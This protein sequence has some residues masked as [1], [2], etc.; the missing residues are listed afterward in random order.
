MM[1]QL[2]PI[3]HIK[4]RSK[5]YNQV[6]QFFS[7]KLILEVETPLLKQ[8]TVTDPY[9]ESLSVKLH[10][11][12][13]Y[14]Q[15]SP[16]FS[17]KSMIAAG[18]GDVFQICKA[19][20]YDEFSTHHQPEFSMLEWYRCEMN[21]HDLMAEAVSLLKL[22]FG[23]LSVQYASYESIFLSILNINP[24][25]ATVPELATVAANHNITLD[26]DVSEFTISDWQNV[27]FSYLI[28][29]KLKDSP[30]TVIYDFPIALSSMAKVNPEN[31][32]VA[33]RFEIYLRGIECVNGY[34]EIERVDD[35]LKRCRVHNIQRKRMNLPSIQYDHDFTHALQKGMPACSGVALGLDRVIMLLS[36]SKSIAE[37]IPR[38][39]V[40][41][42]QYLEQ[43]VA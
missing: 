8:Y 1:N 5:V 39:I 26:V 27:L 4:L 10:D 16:E 13:W 21:Y 15:T 11:E 20:R 19:F 18:I 23:N 43:A 35:Y 29:P 7:S 9:I 3:D 14:L 17:M 34:A 6:R 22:L 37:V 24:F 25:E 33:E 38:H 36:H 28:E 32:E 42:E 40:E 41:S 30:C 12:Q 2:C 31:L